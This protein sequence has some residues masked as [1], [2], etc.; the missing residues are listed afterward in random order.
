[1]VR[2]ARIAP[3]DAAQGRVG[4]ERRRIDADR[5]ALDE[6]R[7]R[8]HLQ[9]PREHRAVR[10][11]IDQA[12]GA[13]DRGVLGRRLLKSQAEEAAQRER[14]S[15]PPRDAAF[16]VDALEVPDQQ[17]PE[18]R[19]W[20]QA[21]PSHARRVERR[22]LGLHKCVERV[23]V[24]DVIQSLVKGVPSSGRQLIRGNPQPWR[25]RAVLATTHRHVGSV[26]RRIDHV[27][28]RLTTGC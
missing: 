21:R 14:I 27:D 2:L 17:Q 19:A 11:Q 5:L 8:Q 23:R 22:A 24:E 20:R 4:L 25:P 16:R 18:I 6:V 12:P 13:R 26:V 3:Y 9:D 10:L 15:G 7:R 28:P 1:M